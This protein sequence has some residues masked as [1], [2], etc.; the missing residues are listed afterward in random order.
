MCSMGMLLILIHIPDFF[1]SV[2]LSRLIQLSRAVDPYNCG[3][4]VVIFLQDKV[5]RQ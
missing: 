4:S 1:I 2:V 5:L 3:I